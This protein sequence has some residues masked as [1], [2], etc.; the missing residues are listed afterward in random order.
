M[1]DNKKAFLDTLKKMKISKKVIEQ[2]DAADMAAFFGNAFEKDFYTGNIIPIGHGQSGDDPLILAR[3][4]DFL[5]LKKSF[6]LLE[7]GTGTGFST[8]LNS[9][10]VKEVVTVEYYE[11]LARSAKER[12]EQYGCG[13]IRHFSGDATEMTVDPGEF[14]AVIILA[15]CVN[16]PYSLLNMLKEGGASVFPMGLPYQQQVV[17]Y[18]NNL[19]APSSMENFSFHDICRF[20]SIR[21]IYGWLEQED[22]T[23]GDY[24]DV[25]RN[26]GENS[27]EE[28]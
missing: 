12:L 13:N 19:D 6:R 2:F 24:R 3:M 22:P 18:I 4:I 20:D 25:N 15:G 5:E 17:R 16:P 23:I 1:S 27:E 9:I 11:D 10:L 7:V 28:N 26:V 21:G 14:D 8:A